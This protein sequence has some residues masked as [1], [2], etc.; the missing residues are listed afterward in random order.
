MIAELSA[1]G[2]VVEALTGFKPLPIMIAQAAVTTIYTCESGASDTS[3]S[4][5]VD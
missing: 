4:L 3:R 1:V 2:Q 5:Q